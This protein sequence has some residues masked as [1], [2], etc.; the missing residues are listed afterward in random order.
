MAHGTLLLL[1]GPNGAGKTTVTR[2]LMGDFL[3]REFMVLNA[4]D[5]TLQKLK[6]A[7]FQTFAE[8]PS[9]RLMSVFIEAA[10]EVEAEAEDLLASG[11]SVC[12]ETVLST[13]KY[14]KM[15]Q[16]QRDRKGRFELVYV[17]LN[18]WHLSARRVKIRASKGGHDVPEDKLEARWNRSLEQLTWFA[19]LADFFTVIDNSS[20]ERGAPDLLLKAA[21]GVV[22]YQASTDKF[23]PELLEALRLAFPQSPL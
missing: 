21:T 20:E 22:A 18:D 12:L 9:E 1:A 8:V 17:A 2:Q 5:R 23:F 16:T 19:P 14:R 13:A 15:V 3:S 7:G 11:G 10:R 4:D 6:R